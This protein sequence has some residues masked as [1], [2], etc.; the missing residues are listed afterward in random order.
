MTVEY[1]S[2][3]F[4]NS[5]VRYMCVVCI[6]AR[7]RRGIIDTRRRH[8]WVV[9]ISLKRFRCKGTNTPDRRGVEDVRYLSIYLPRKATRSLFFESIQAWRP[10]T[11]YEQCHN[12]FAPPTPA[13]AVAVTTQC[14]AVANRSPPGSIVVLRSASNGGGV[15]PF[16]PRC[17]RFYTAEGGGSLLSPVFGFI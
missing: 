7:S 17:V 4:S 15:A 6:E 10:S 9:G 2:R 8:Q 16:R 5:F 13:A 11:Y 14:A 12:S 3:L 1:C